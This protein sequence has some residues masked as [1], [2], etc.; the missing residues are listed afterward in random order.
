[1]ISI[2][3]IPFPYQPSTTVSHPTPV[4]Q[5]QNFGI[6]MD[7]IRH[8]LLSRK[9]TATALTSQ[10]E[11]S[12]NSISNS[13]S[14]DYEP[15]DLS[16]NPQLTCDSVPLYRCQWPNCTYTHILQV[17][18]DH[19]MLQHSCML[20]SPDSTASSPPMHITSATSFNNNFMNYSN[21]AVNVMEFTCVVNNCW[22]KFKTQKALNLHIK[23]SHD[24]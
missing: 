4:E 20:A 6:N 16:Y 15:Q 2:I 1:M 8:T 23:K 11:S 24:M 3:S 5:N 9:S 21:I 19:H 12:F 10:S 7:I 14:V 13:N 17:N 22:R 18:V